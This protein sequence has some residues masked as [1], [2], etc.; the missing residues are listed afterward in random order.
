MED[1]ATVDLVAA[2][3]G[4]AANAVSWF[5][6]KAEFCRVFRA[7]FAGLVTGDT[8]IE[9]RLVNVFENDAPLPAWRMHNP[10]LEASRQLSAGISKPRP[11][12]ALG[13]EI[14]D[15]RQYIRGEYY[16]DYGSRLEMRHEVGTMV[17]VGRTSMTCFGLYRPESAGP[18]DERDRAALAEV[19]PHLRRALQLRETLRPGLSAALSG[20]AILEAMRQAVVLVDRDLR[21]LHANPPAIA[22]A[23][24]NKRF[25][26]LSGTSYGEG[27][28]QTYVVVD[29]HDLNASLRQVVASVSS[30][31][32]PGSAIRIPASPNGEASSLILAVLPVPAS[33]L[34]PATPSGTRRGLALLFVRKLAAPSVPPP[35]I[36]CDLFGLTA[37]EA[38][39]AV[40][41]ARGTTAAHVA[42]AR[43][44]SVDTVRTQL[45]VVLSKLGARNL[46]ELEYLLGALSW[47]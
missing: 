12:V 39:V 40:A 46:R 29:D 7:P 47:I 3:Y 18:F 13:P 45:R 8:S 9:G 21:I 32:G 17:E 31:G 37:S 19:R 4:A 16:A 44:V 36:L 11:V 6:V 10:F 5:A 35:E 2:C 27:A 15:D 14:V 33:L 22:I 38:A 43:R 20:V 42:I 30:L 41:L 1:D 34:Q 24:S 23:A 26:F 28:K 25:S